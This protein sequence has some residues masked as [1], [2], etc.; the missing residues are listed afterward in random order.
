MYDEANASITD[1]LLEKSGE[2]QT[3]PYKRGAS[4]V[5]REMKNLVV[6]VC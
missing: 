4:G 5:D 1:P 3:T 6:S 2:G